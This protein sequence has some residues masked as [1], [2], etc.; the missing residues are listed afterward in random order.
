MESKRSSNSSPQ[1]GRRQS[2]QKS[3]KGGVG[4]GFDSRTFKEKSKVRFLS[5]W[6]LEVTVSEKLK[7]KHSVYTVSPGERCNSARNQL[8]IHKIFV[9]ESAWGN[10][11]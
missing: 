8:E 3:Q 6:K 11:H 7:P 5:W 4:I 10:N 2:S 9:L 1:P